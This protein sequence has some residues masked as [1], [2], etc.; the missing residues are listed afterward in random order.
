M[1]KE[2]YKYSV[3]IKHLLRVLH[4]LQNGSISRYDDDKPV[5]HI[6][7]WNYFSNQFRKIKS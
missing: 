1:E 2:N 5:K 4:L 6:L 3:P 7:S